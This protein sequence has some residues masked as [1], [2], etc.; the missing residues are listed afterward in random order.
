MVD[1]MKSVDLRQTSSRWFTSYVRDRTHCMEVV[2]FVICG[3]INTG[4][5][6]LMY[7]WLLWLT[8]YAIAYTLSY[9]A[10][11]FLS[12]WLNTKFVFR[13]PLSISRAHQYPIVYLVQYLLGM[14]FLFLLVE[15]VNLSE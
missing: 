2:R 6:F 13:E 1:G 11:I 12:Y 14:A 10:G 15:V 7:L 4:V 5:T 8:S 9:V 3:V